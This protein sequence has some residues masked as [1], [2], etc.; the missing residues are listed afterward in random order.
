MY[1]DNRWCTAA[2][3]LPTLSVLNKVQTTL[4]TI[5]IRNNNNDHGNLHTPASIDLN[6]K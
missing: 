3:T 6:A 2:D 5:G 4:S 1:I